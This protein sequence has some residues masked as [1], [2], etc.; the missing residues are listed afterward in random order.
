MSLP[1]DPIGE[2]NYTVEIV[3][4]LAPSVAAQKCNVIFGGKH[5]KCQTFVAASN[6]VTNVTIVAG[7]HDYSDVGMI[8]F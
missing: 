2:C 8:S 3:Q 1:A 4:Y 5:H 6:D 7:K